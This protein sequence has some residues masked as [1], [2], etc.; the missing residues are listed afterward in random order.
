MATSTIKDSKG[1]K[2]KRS[3]DNLVVSQANF[4]L[5]QEKKECEKKTPNGKPRKG[6][7]ARGA[8]KKK[9]VDVM[10]GT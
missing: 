10:N 3:R 2:K 7:R 8:T 1:V 5:C 6:K 9:K 4:P